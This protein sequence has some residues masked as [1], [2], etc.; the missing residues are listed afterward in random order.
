MSALALLVF[1]Q[2]RVAA[3]AGI[4][5]LRTRS[6]APRVARGTSFDLLIRHL[7]ASELR[8]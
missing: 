3:E 8:A 2:R 1:P 6:S 5:A 7:S 4:A